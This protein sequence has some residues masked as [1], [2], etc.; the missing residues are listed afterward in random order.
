[1]DFFSAYFF[2]G[3]SLMTQ[4]VMGDAHEAHDLLFDQWELEP[5]QR[6]T[7]R[8]FIILFGSLIWPLIMGMTYGRK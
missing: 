5:W 8:G 7:A 3:V 6:T 2:I 1:M 4:R